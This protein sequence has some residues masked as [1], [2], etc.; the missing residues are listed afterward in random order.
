M[1]NQI[2]CTQAGRDFRWDIFL[3][4]ELGQLY[5]AIPFSSL[6]TSFPSLPS[7][8]APGFF[9]IEGMIALQVLKA[10]LNKVGLKALSYQ[11]YNKRHLRHGN[12][13]I[14]TLNKITLYLFGNLGFGPV[15][16]FLCKKIK[17]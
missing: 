15:H 5:Q 4:M 6:A 10:Y 12:P 7:R 1:E 2:F 9:G 17:H 14:N 3:S 8:G 16:F 13:F 11:G